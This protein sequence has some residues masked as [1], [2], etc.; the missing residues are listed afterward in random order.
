MSRIL[1]FR[2]QFVRIYGHAAGASSDLHGIRRLTHCSVRQRV[3]SDRGAAT[4]ALSRWCPSIRMCRGARRVSTTPCDV[5]GETTLPR[6]C[7]GRAKGSRSTV[8]A[9]RTAI[10]ASRT[11]HWPLPDGPLAPPGRPIGPSRTRPKLISCAWERISVSADYPPLRLV[12]TKHR[13]AS[14]D[15]FARPQAGVAGSA[16]GDAGLRPRFCRWYWLWKNRSSSRLRRA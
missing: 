4:T 1:E 6:G 12:V 8:Q 3:R 7:F 9:S 13:Q 15:D 5:V 14:L 11:T 16:G 2:P 10:Q